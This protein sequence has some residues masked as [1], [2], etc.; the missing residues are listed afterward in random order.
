MTIALPRSAL[1]RLAMALVLA[2]TELWSAAGGAEAAEDRCIAVSEAPGLRGLVRR[3]Q[4]RPPGSP[5]AADDGIKLT[6]VGHSTFLIE[7]RQGVKIAT[8]FNDYVRPAVLPDIVTMNRAHSTH[9]TDAPDP[10][11]RHVLRGWNPA[12]GPAVHDL[13]ERDVRVRNI[14]TNIRS[15]ASGGTDEFG[16]SIFIFEL[17]ALCI[18]HLGHLHHTLSPRQIA[19][20]GQMDVVLAPVDGSYT[21]DTPGMIEV[22]K[23]LKAPLVIPMHY[24]SGF[25]LSRF[26]DVARPD[27]EV[28][29]SDVSSITLTRATL[30]RKPQILV[31]PGG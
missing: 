5:P 8:D 12:G 28:K 30:P 27:F 2:A 25:T 23:G 24:F 1:L 17:G 16:N 13:T 3:A 19:Q 7:S 18:A 31:L 22:L 10:A 6:Y 4:F 21:L 11:V 15:Y 26:L 29:T 14:P 9:Y 20:I